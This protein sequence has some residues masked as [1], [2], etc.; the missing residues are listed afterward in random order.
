MEQE[1]GRVE[2][3]RHKINQ[4][5]RPDGRGLGRPEGQRS[6]EKG[7]AFGMRIRV[8]EEL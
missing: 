2:D 3:L 6:V 5:E 7:R 8:M 1:E 4:S